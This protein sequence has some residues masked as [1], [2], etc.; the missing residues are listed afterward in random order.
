MDKAQRDRWYE[1]FTGH[2]FTFGKQDQRP[3]TRTMYLTEKGRI[4]NYNSFNESYWDIQ[5]DKFTFYDRDHDATTSFDLPDEP[6]LLADNTLIGTYLNDPELKHVLRARTGEA[7][8]PWVM[9]ELDNRLQAD[10]KPIQDGVVEGL[11]K[12]KATTH[13]EIRIAFLINS[14]ETL[15]A[16]LPLIDATRADKRFEMKLIVSDKVF[17]IV[18]PLHTIEPL[19]AYLHAHH[20]NYVKV[21]RDFFGAVHRLE[22]WQPDFIIRQSEWDTDWPRAFA[23]KNLCWS[24]LIYVPYVITESFLI[25]PD[26]KDSLLTND[27]YQYI[28]RYFMPEPLLPE[29]RNEIESSYIST[30][31]FS[32]VGSMKAIQIKNAKPAWP[33]EAD[34][35]KKVI[36]MA[37][38]SIFDGWY[39]FGAFLSIHDDMIEWAKNHPELSILFN[40]HPLLYE[41]MKLGDTHSLM[42][43]YNTFLDAWNALPNTGILEKAV[44]YPATQAAD[45]VLTD[46]I[47]SLYEMQIQTKPIVGLIRPD[48]SAWGP[49][50]EKLMRGIHV[51]QTAEEAQ[52]EVER[53]LTEPNDLASVEAENTAAWVANRHPETAII[54]EMVQEM[55]QQ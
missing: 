26:R 54:N 11:Q 30:S 18:D 35:K 22:L 15:P 38:H 24:R 43:E 19:T 34:G 6:A 5:D 49:T 3:Y 50:G 12:V 47:S 10:L 55:A 42:K 37:H 29:Q 16:L 9:T 25:A 32:P 52:A 21:E 41:N 28:W 40:P 46:G 44:Q 27:Y 8:G 23:G 33:L 4:G 13:H 53:L 20:Y 14:L 31:V 48:H 36:W 17:Q 7:S 51:V 1:Y 2:Y 45:V 39:N